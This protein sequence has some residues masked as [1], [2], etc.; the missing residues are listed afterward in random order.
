MAATSD[1]TAARMAAEARERKRVFAQCERF[2]VGHGPLRPHAALAELAREVGT[3][4]E[5]DHYGEG[6]LIEDFERE[7][8]ELLGKE[9]ALFLPSGTMAQQIALRIWS[10]RKRCATV[11]FHPTCH[12]ELHEQRGYARLHGLHARLVGEAHRLLTLADLEGVAEPVAALLLE[13]PQRE[14]GGQLPTWDALVAQT[15]W[16]RERGAAVHMDGARLWE[17]APFY[18]RSYAE[19]AALFESVYV[20]FYKGVGALAGAALAGPAEYIAEARVWQR[21]HGGNLI[22]LFPYVV[23]ARVRLRERLPRFS[24]YHQGAMRIAAV[25]SAIP[26]IALTPDPPHAHMMHVTLR[27]DTERLL[28]ASLQIAREERVALFSALAPTDVPGI[29]KFELWVGDAA[30]A[31]TDEEISAYFTRILAAGE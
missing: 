5:S 25:L 4:E 6:E 8:A 10:E 21:R 1:A 9:S 12:L 23:S 3:A 16:G 19:I 11:A 27:G 29:A 20:S 2:L 7:V 24:A 14:I 30:S 31:L 17:A 28:A 13:L 18:G 22:R 26:G 15:A